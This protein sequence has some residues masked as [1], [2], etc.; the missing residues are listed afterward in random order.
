MNYEL[1]HNHNI[2]IRCGIYYISLCRGWSGVQLQ[3][4]VLEL[5]N[6]HVSLTLDFTSL[7]SDD[8]KQQAFENTE[9]IIDQRK[10]IIVQEV[11]IKSKFVLLYTSKLAFAVVSLYSA[12]KR[13]STLLLVLFQFY[14]REKAVLMHKFST[15]FIL[16]SM[17]FCIRMS[18]TFFSIYVK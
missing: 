13:F 8:L 12:L 18:E 3:C 17:C 16:E 4:L 15:D 6:G 7:Q 5:K 9:N 10:V 2:I 14:I 1:C 11:F